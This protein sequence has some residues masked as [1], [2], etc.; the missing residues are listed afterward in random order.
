M[1]KSAQK[2]PV[3]AVQPPADNAHLP[4]TG[5]TMQK[6]RTGLI[7][8]LFMFGSHF[9]YALQTNDLVENF[10][11]LDHRGSAHELYRHADASAIVFLVQGNGCPIV[12]NVMPTLREMR[13]RYA[14]QGVQFFLINSNLQDT[15]ESITREVE[16][17]GYDMPVLLDQQQLIGEAL[18][19]VRTGEIFVVN[20]ATWQIAYH[21]AIDDRL[22]YENQKPKASRE[23]LASA[24]DDLLANRPVQLTQTRA[25]GCLINF[26][27]RI[28]G[29]SRASISY[30]ETIAPILRDNCVTCHRSGGIGPWAMTDYNMVRGFAPM[31]R[32]VLRTRRMPPWHADPAVGHFSNDRALTDIEVKQLVHWVETGAQRGDGPDALTEDDRTWP[33]WSLGEPD[34]I[35][36]VPA[37]NVAATGTI[38]YQYP[39]IRNPIGRDVWVRAAEVL[40]GD[41]KALHHVIT[42]FGIPAA[43]GKFDRSRS[44]TLGGY[45]PGAKADVFPDDTGV[46]LPRDAVFRPQMHRT[47]Y[48]KAS[49]DQSRI[50]LYFHADKPIH[51]L[52]SMVLAND[53][54]SIPARTR[55]HWESA[56][57]TVD[58]DILLYSLLPHAHYRGKASEF[59][60]YYPNGTD[61]I[62]LSV[63][64]YDFNWQTTYELAEPKR[65]PAGT[66]LVH[67][68][69]WDNSATNPANPDP[70]RV[71]PWGEQSWDEMLFGA[72]T[73]RYLTDGESDQ[74][75]STIVSTR[76]E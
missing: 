52:H 62:L 1:Q 16:E 43:D 7:A 73:Y 42:N 65:I 14:G 72:L 64:S 12:R 71:V 26:P 75:A 29:S 44:G 6:L 68:T 69:S 39:V 9:A 24:L 21:G 49:T 67:R 15:R 48:G 47:T 58:R 13:E 66:R 55:E 61:E 5:N 38:D 74:T 23:H 46:L 20:P 60:A 34:A 2:T 51:E 27:E 50:G 32:E 37:M 25:I 3:E 35:I 53:R 11:L 22:S 18:G 56:E 4:A 57:R 59:R 70:D 54:I 8:M 10:R 41:R 30:S 33:E 40:P 19:F 63:P 31:I 76:P 45:V 36:E 17:F 28:A